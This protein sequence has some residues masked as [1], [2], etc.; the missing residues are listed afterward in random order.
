M[1]TR[2]KICGITRLEDAV[3]AVDHGADAIGF[4]L[5]DGSARCVD[6]ARMAGI[7]C[8]LPSFVSVVTVFVNPSGDEVQAALDACP[9]AVLQFH[10]EE[11]P[12][13]CAQFRRPW[14]KAARAKPGSDLIEYLSPF[15]AASGWMIDAYHDRLYGGTGCRFDWSLVPRDLS[16]PLIVSGG[17]TAE[18]VGD[19]IR[20]LRPFAVDISSGVEREKG[21]KDAAKIAAFIAGV[22]HADQ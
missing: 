12:A 18:N 10:G 15:S 21:I 4:V 1:R 11:T 7:A 22:K 16:R 14:I 9:G 6:P 3:A 8:T 17:L 13:F 20:A 19:A 2:V 5:W